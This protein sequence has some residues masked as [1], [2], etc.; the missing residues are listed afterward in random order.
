MNHLEANISLLAITFFSAVQFVFLDGVPNN[1]SPFGFLCITNFVGFLLTVVF[2]TDEIKRIDFEHI[3]QGI[4]LSVELIVF[5][6]AYLAGVKWLGA[7]EATAVQQIYFIFVVMFIILFYKQFPDRGQ[8]SGF[9]LITAGI[10]CMVDVNFYAL[11][12]LP[13]L[14]LI[15]ADIAFAFYIISIW[16]YSTSSNPAALAL[17]QMLFVCIGA[18]ILWAVDVFFFGASF[19]MPM[20]GDFWASV[21]FVGFFIRA[22]YGFIQIYAQR[23]VSPLNVAIIFSTE[24]VISVF[25]SPLLSIVFGTEAHDIRFIDFIGGIFILFGLLM[26]QPDFIKF[27]RRIK[28]ARG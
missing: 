16:R 11:W 6:I 15:I 8:I 26:I 25:L 13:V 21:L 10:F 9:V 28:N 5:N 1:I 2:F 14:Y 3:K 19:E 22:L 27:V 7:N 24:I 4:I 23:Y 17:G 20:T 18:F 12:K